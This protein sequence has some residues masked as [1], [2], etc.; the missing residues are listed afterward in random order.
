M[1]WTVLAPVLIEHLAVPALVAVGGWL[2]TKLPG[3]LKTWLQADT[4]AKDMALL[5]GALSRG[6]VAAYKDY[7]AGRLASPGAAIQQVVTYVLKSVP[8]TVNKLGPTQEVLT[9]MA[10]AAWDQWVV[11]AKAAEAP[12]VVIKQ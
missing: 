6:A 8:D 9:T 4:H 12:A 10:H 3:P 5:L 7:D 2:V 1:D 11:Q